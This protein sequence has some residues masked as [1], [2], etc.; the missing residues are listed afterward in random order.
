[1]DRERQKAHEQSSEESLLPESKAPGFTIVPIK[2]AV[3]E[4]AINGDEKAFEALFMGTYRYVYAT[5]RQYLKNEQDIYDAIQDTYLKVYKSLSRLRSAASFYPWLHRICENC[6]KDILATNRQDTVPLDAEVAEIADDDQI[7]RTNVSTD[8]AEI[9]KQLP[10]EQAELLIRVYYDKLRVVEIARMQGLPVSTVHNRLNA[11]KKRLKE[12]LKTRGIDKPVYGGDLFATLS[13]AIRDA[14]GTELLSMAVAEEILHTVTGSKNKKGATVVSRFAHKQRSQAALKIA[15]LLLL[16]CLLLTVI[17]LIAVALITKSLYPPN[18]QTGTA[19]TTTAETSTTTTAEAS[20]AN[21]AETSTTTAAETTTAPSQTADTSDTT[22]TASTPSTA[23][24]ASTAPPEKPE[25]LT[26]S[27]ADTEILG[28]HTEDGAVPIATTGESVYAI[29]GGDLVAVQTGQAT[30]RVCIPDFGALYGETGQ[31]LNVYGDHIYWVNQNAQGQFVLNRCN[32]A[33]KEQHTVVFTETDCTYLTEMTV[34]ADGVYFLAGIHGEHSYR[35][36]GTLYRTDHDFHIEKQ[37][38]DVAS[39]ALKGTNVYILHGNG[40]AGTPFCADRATFEQVEELAVAAP[41]NGLPFGT[42]YALGDYLA[43]AGYN[44]YIH[45][46]TFACGDLEIIEIAT[47]RA[48]RRIYTEAGEVCAIR[49]I[50]DDN[51][52]TLIYTF[53][54]APYLYTVRTGE[55]RPLSCADGTVFKGKRYTVTE[56]GLYL[57]DIDGSSPQKIA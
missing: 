22:V 56:D 27:F 10:P 37:L 5:A 31:W 41:N 18:K 2:E 21:T 19:S 11:A 55:N 38:N 16:A 47:G 33:G 51:G 29:V 28:T 7:D 3:I 14:I 12:L 54:G 34:A 36:S 20:T 24:T 48:V 25:V 17:L 57:S 6:A 1:M 35:K 39:Y 15:S 32:S 26:G 44:P 43:V 45:S 40:N 8:I 23:T 4:K 50:S 13:A 9:L 53:N 49:S 30:A 46:E 42:V 52:G